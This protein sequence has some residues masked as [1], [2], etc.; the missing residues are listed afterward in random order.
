VRKIEKRPRIGAHLSIGQGLDK[1]A[2][3]A[4]AKGVETLPIFLRNPRG[5]SA[6]KLSEYEI[7]YFTKKLLENDIYPLIVHIPYICNPASVKEDLYDFACE[8]VK[9]DLERCS[10]VKAD[11]L[12]LHPGSYTTSTSDAGIERIADLLNRVLDEYTG[13]TMILLETMSGQGTEIGRNFDELGSIVQKINRSD[14]V[15]ICFDTCHLFAAGYDCKSSEGLNELL[16]QAN[17]SFGWDRIKVLHANDSR[18]ELGS[19]RDRHAHIGEGFIG[20]EG[21]ERLV[22]SSFFQDIPFILETAEDKLKEDI[23]ILKKMRR[24]Y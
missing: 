16:E 2:D 18:T 11:Y 13:D 3:E 23:E 1:T 8:T 21:F 20:T 19:H 15:G 17:Q 12:V 14:K 4:I 24:N 9:H 5:R 7:D 6:R 22:K 10:L